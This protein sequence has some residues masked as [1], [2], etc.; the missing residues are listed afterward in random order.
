MTRLIMEWQI[1]IAVII[2]IQTNVLE[3]EGILF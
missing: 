2:D 3:F 1:V